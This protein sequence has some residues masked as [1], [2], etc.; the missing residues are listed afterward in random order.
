MKLMLVSIR[1]LGERTKK[2]FLK[3]SIETDWLDIMLIQ[4]T[5]GPSETIIVDL[6]K[7]FPGWVFHGLDSD[8]LS[9]GIIIGI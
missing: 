6:V 9:R 7:L 3:H 4:E 2:M 5:M 1:G 8:G